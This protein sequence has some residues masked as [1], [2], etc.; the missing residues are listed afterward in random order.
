MSEEQKNK[1]EDLIA[2]IDKAEQDDP[3]HEELREDIIE[4]LNNQLLKDIPKV[5]KS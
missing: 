4:F 2:K 3:I 1:W 5:N